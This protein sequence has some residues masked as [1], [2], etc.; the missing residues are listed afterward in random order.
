MA[1]LDLQFVQESSTAWMEANAS[2]V[3]YNG[4][5]TVKIAKLTV[6]GM[7]NYDRTTGFPR[8]AVSLV[9]ETRTLTKDRGKE[10][11]LDSM[12]YNETNFVTGA[13]VIMS[14]FQRAQV[15]PEVDAFRYSQIFQLANAGLRTGSYTPSANTVLSQIRADV[16]SIQDVIG[17]AEPLVIAI[18]HSAAGLLDDS[19]DIQKFITSTDFVNGQL[20]TK[21]KALDGIPFFRIPSARF[22]TSITLGTNG[23]TWAADAMAINWIIMTRSAVIAIVKT[24]K[25]RI[26]DPATN[27]RMDAWLI[28]YR[29]YHDLWILDNKLPAIYVSYTPKAVQAL[30]STVAQGAASGATKFTA[31]AA[32]GNTLAYVKQAGA[33][34]APAQ[35]DVLTGGTAY[36]SGSD[37]AASAT[38][39]L[40]MYE[41]DA[42]GHVVKYAVKQLAAGDIK[43]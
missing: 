32:S 26:F 7:G 11:V 12:D 24:D 39:Y 41:I 9:W 19:P 40:G 2:Q 38:E 23:F 5:N 27:Q 8:G 13:G 16:R 10:F 1:M 43:S 34:T 21:T 17:E 25:P 22:K 3:Q 30:T 28:Q 18:S 14:E 15:I 31:T 35:N 20:N 6:E 36:V 33:I 42:V 4:G 29:K 37:I